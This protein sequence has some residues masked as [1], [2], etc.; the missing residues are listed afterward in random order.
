M[1]D[2]LRETKESDCYVRA[3]IQANFGGLKWGV[4][5]LSRPSSSYVESG[6][7]NFATEISANTNK[8]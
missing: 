3:S 1:G 5:S 7:A 4:G 6:K 8:S 2:V